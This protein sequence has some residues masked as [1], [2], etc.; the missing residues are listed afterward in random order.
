MRST[1]VMLMQTHIGDWA[2]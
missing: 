1:P 2:S